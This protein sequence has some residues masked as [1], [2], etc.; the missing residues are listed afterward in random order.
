MRGSNF[1][2]HNARI[3]QLGY[4]IVFNPREQYMHN[5]TKRYTKVYANIEK[6]QD[7]LH[8]LSVLQLC[9]G[10]QGTNIH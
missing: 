8:I 3:N 1:L 10:H 7:K 6:K 2:V 9:F 4:Q 5:E